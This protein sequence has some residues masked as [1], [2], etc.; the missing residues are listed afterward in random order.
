MTADD[1]GSSTRT[2]T[3]PTAAPLGAGTAK[4]DSPA[5]VP[6]TVTACEGVSRRST[7]VSGV[8]NWMED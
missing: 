4:V 8:T 7:P 5:A 2:R 3:T 6:T 1:R